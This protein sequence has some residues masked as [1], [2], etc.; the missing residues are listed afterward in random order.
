MSP[1]MILIALVAVAGLILVLMY[2]SLIGKKNELANA[3][4]SID[5]QLKQ[6]HDLIPNLIETVRQYMQHERG[7]LE[8]LTKLRA[9]ALGG[10]TQKAQV[11]NEISRKLGGI[12][13][14]AEN[15][16]QL[17][18]DSTF[19]TLQ[20]SLNEVEAQI[21]AARRT[22]NA[23]VT[24][25]NNAIEMFPTNLLAGPMGLKRATVLETPETERA[26]VNVGALFKA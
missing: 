2:N 14:A 10:G 20:R 23:A 19:V 16:P 24:D 7:T 5:V 22:Y 13:V 18:A 25:L 1:L 9:Q 4:G 26:N 21:A 17:K 15:Y 3:F 6:R 11:E 8:E 12:L